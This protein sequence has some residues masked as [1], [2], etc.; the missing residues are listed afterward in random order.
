MAPRS[1]PPR[2]AD[3]ARKWVLPLLLLGGLLAMHGLG[4][5]TQLR[6]VP[7]V[8]QHM[9]ATMASGCHDLASHD[10]G[11]FDHGDASC[12]AAGVGTSPTLPELATD[13]IPATARPTATGSVTAASAVGRDPPS[14]SDLQLLRI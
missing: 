8:D 5:L 9:S 10:G 11:H 3:R 13:Q 7:P 12:K 1:R 14:L 6:D 4:Q 2:L